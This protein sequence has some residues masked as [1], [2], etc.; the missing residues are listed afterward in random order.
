MNSYSDFTDINYDKIGE[1]Y[2]SNIKSYECF[3]PL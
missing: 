1:Y 3:E 2:F